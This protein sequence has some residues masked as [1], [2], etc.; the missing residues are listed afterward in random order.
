METLR[1]SLKLYSTFHTDLLV[2]KECDAAFTSIVKL[3]LYYRVRGR[4]LNIYIPECRAYR[5][6]YQRAFT[7]EV[8]TIEDEV[9]I[10]FLTTMIREKR[11]MAFVRSVL[12]DALICP[13]EFRFERLIGYH[14][15]DESYYFAVNKKSSLASAGAFSFSLLNDTP[16]IFMHGDELSPEYPYRLCSTLDFEPGTLYFTDTRE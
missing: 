13:D 10:L 9:T 8:I 6:R 7:K 15:Y 11:R 16:V 4:K 5:Y 2:L 3:A 12:Y 1:I 14:L